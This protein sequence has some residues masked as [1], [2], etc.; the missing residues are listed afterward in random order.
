VLRE[1]STEK[2]SFEDIIDYI[3]RLRAAR[4][5]PAIADAENRES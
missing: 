2:K 3:K 5:L 4:G 1:R